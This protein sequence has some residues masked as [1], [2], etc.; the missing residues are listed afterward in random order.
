MDHPETE[1]MLIR[2]QLI[3]LLFESDKVYFTYKL[4]RHLES[5]EEDSQRVFDLLNKQLTSI[6]EP[7]LSQI[8]AY[9]IEQAQILHN[10]I[11]ETALKE[12]TAYEQ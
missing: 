2:Q 7:H 1:S 3:G 8:E 9:W 12:G 5:D 10:K 6:G 11:V 4:G